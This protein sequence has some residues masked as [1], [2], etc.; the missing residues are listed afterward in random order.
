MKTAGVSGSFRY[1]SGRT[2]AEMLLAR[3]Q[4]LGLGLWVFGLLP[5]T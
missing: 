5:K 2:V 4:I 3:V 1:F